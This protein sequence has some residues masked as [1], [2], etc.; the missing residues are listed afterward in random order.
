MELIAVVDG[1][2]PRSPPVSGSAD[3]STSET[4]FKPKSVSQ[5]VHLRTDAV[6]YCTRGHRCE[7]RMMEEWI[8]DGNE[9]IKI[10]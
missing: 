6:C 1:T 4:L 5:R 7:R 10:K 2:A 3:T 9:F 8:S